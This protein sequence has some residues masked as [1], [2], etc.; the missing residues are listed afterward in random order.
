MNC[1]EQFHCTTSHQATTTLITQ[2]KSHNNPAK[3]WILGKSL[4]QSYASKYWQITST[5][6][7]KLTHYF[8]RDEIGFLFISLCCSCWSKCFLIRGK[9]VNC[10]SLFN[11]SFIVRFKHT[12]RSKK[13]SRNRLIASPSIILPR[14]GFIVLPC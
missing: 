9:Y 5:K 4:L 2:F 6:C 8:K 11:K 3:L 10:P 12:M 13:E 1:T 7:K 14:N